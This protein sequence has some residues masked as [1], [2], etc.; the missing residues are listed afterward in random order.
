MLAGV[1]GAGAAA[2][3]GGVSHASVT[4]LWRVI[5]IWMLMLLLLLVL[6]LVMVY[7]PSSSP[8]AATAP[9]TATLLVIFSCAQCF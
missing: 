4:L 9:V 8:A 1:P 2:A 3:E 6:Q 5:M 7:D